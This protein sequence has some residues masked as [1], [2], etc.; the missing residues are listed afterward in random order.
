MKRRGSAVAVTIRLADLQER[1]A[2]DLVDATK[3]LGDATSKLVRATWGLV[4]ATGLLVL[5]EIVLKLV[6][7]G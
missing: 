2:R 5:A 7:R 3:G 1:S 4:V 6:F